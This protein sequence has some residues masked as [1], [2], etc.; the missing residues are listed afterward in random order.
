MTYKAFVSMFV[1]LFFVAACGGRDE[2]QAT[3]EPTTT[4]VPIATIAPTATSMPTALPTSVLEA[5]ETSDD[6]SQF[7]DPEVIEV[8]MNDLYYGESNDNIANPPVWTVTSGADVSVVME[9]RSQAL[10]HNWAIVKAGEEV[11]T[12]FLG[13]EQ[14]NVVLLDAGVLDANQTETFNFTAPEL[15]EYMVICTVAGHYP[16]M[17]GKLVVTE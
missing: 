11:P 9:N 10:Q 15:G 14:M 8:V 7:I 12:P 4:P 13:E 2:P 6:S 17:Q 16:V 1:V 3:L 5:T